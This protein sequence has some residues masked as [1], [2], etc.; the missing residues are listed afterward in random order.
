MCIRDSHKGVGGDPVEVAH[1]NGVE[2]PV[3]SN[4][5][6][7]DVH[8]EQLGLAGLDTD[9]ALNGSLR[10]LGGIETQIFD[11]ILIGR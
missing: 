10:T 2:P 8:I 7:I 9:G 3:E 1:V 11:T 5:L 4:R 6:H